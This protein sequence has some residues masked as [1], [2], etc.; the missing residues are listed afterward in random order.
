MATLAPPAADIPALLAK[1]RAFPRRI[2]ADSRRV[3]PGVAFAA[4][5][6]MHA[7]GRQFVPD[8]IARGATA[9]L[10]E[11]SGFAWNREWQV[12]HLPIEGLQQRLGAIADFI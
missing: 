5:P 10:W 6:G 1:L 2:T 11:S 8:A 4:Y 3:E 7:D 9:V 12:P